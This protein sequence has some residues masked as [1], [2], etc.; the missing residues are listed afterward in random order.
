MTPGLDSVFDL[1]IKEI[2]SSDTWMVLGLWVKKRNKG[3]MCVVKAK[4][5][6]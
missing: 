1:K 4:V 3:Q 2:P 6:C 5:S